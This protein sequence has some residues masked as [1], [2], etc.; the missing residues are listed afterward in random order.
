MSL[1]VFLHSV[2]ES[3]QTWQDQVAAMPPGTKAA[4]PWLHG[5]RPGRD[6][7]FSIEAAASDVWP[8]LPQFGTDAMDV[9][10]SGLGAVVALHLA[11]ESPEAVSRLVLSAGYVNPPPGVM[12]AQRIA[13][14]LVPR[15][16]LA[17]AGIDKKRFVA[18][19][20]AAASIDYRGSLKKVTADTL[21]L[22]GSQDRVNR[23]SAEQ[24]AAG[25][26]QARLAVIDGA[27]AS[28]HTDAPRAFNEVVF[29]FL[30]PQ[31][32]PGR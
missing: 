1:I 2:G 31:E 3:P 15:R 32:N 10:G 9:V 7:R 24:L 18:A 5:L 8:L 17:K 20:E 25:I 22:I 26:P 23:P 13:A 29:D 27:G 11:V 19:L 30:R 28:I 4:A 12:R 16:R 21:V 6:E 14:S